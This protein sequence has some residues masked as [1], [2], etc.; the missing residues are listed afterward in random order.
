VQRSL[1]TQNFG[2]TYSKSPVKR[3]VLRENHGHSRYEM[4]A[5]PEGDVSILPEGCTKSISESS[6][7]GSN[8]TNFHK[9]IEFIYW[10]AVGFCGIIE[11]KSGTLCPTGTSSPRF[12]I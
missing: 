3:D 5:V 12:P 11:D 7:P 9:S 6:L 2:F 1:M 4:I 8:V 10:T